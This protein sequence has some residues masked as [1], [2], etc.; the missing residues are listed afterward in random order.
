M[1]LTLLKI[2]ANFHS[3]WSFICWAPG[4]IYSNWRP[5][6]SFCKPFKIFVI[7]SI[8]TTGIHIKFIPSFLIF[9]QTKYHFFSNLT[10]PWKNNSHNISAVFCDQQPI[11]LTSKSGS[12][13]WVHIKEHSFPKIFE[14]LIAILLI[15][16]FFLSLGASFTRLTHTS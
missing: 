11:L 16:P 2:V 13:R 7:S 14:P 4:C 1:A 9:N 10:F 12:K 3:A 15:P 5:I 6:L 8:V